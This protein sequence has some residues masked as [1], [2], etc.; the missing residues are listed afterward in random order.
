MVEVLRDCSPRLRFVAPALAELA[1]R[2]RFS[3]CSTGLE[4]N[5]ILSGRPRGVQRQLELGDLLGAPDRA[6]RKR[7]PEVHCH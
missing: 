1:T 4:R 3:T 5:L 6:R 7:E 2:L